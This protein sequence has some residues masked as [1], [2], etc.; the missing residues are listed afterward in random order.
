MKSQ[1]CSQQPD[2]LEEGLR[3]LAR[4]TRPPRRLPEAGDLWWRAEII[5]RWVERE[6]AVR[7]AERPLLWSRVIAFI[8][9]LLTPVSLAAAA[10]PLVAILVAGALAPLTIFLGWLLLQRDA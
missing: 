9:V 6:D 8:L 2:T 4:E 7:E 5:R 10:P 1:D 3:Q